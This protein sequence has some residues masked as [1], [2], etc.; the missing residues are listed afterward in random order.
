[1]DV[2]SLLNSNPADAEQRKQ[3]DG[4]SSKPPSRSR[5]P[6]DAGGYSLPINTVPK[7]ARMEDPVQFDNY[8]D[9]A[10]INS[11]PLSS[12]HKFSDS[13]S[14]LSSFASSVQWT[15]THSR[16]S[17]TS[18]LDSNSH[19]HQKSLSTDI[20]SPELRSI[21][22]TLES[23]HLSWKGELRQAT[24]PPQGASR[25]QTGSSLEQ[26]APVADNHLSEQGEE[27][28]S[29]GKE[30]MDAA[31]ANLAAEK[32]SKTNASNRPGSPSDAVLI[33]RS[34]IPTLRVFT[35][36]LSGHQQL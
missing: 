5:T 31:S 6:W 17:S 24:E 27:P 11:P 9:D 25:P 4:G 3:A 12:G 20:L 32:S 19:T 1:M 26:L 23:A 33:K 8:Q 35:G 29:Q 7:S 16:F 14:S 34:S 18:T 15:T 36:Y 2:G 22:H 21:A 10:G 28:G 13:R 30:M